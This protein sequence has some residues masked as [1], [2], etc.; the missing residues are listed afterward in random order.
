MNNLRLYAAIPCLFFFL[1]CVENEIE[2]FDVTIDIQPQGSATIEPV[3]YD[4]LF[5]GDSIS[6]TIT[7]HNDYQ[8]DQWS[9][10]VSSF[11]STIT[12]FGTQDYD[13]TALLL[14]V[15][16]LSEQVQVYI[17]PRIDPNPI[18]AIRLGAKSSVVLNKQGETVAEYEFENRLG[19]DLEMLPN[20]EFIGI[21]KPDDRDYFSFGG[22]GG[23][24]RRVTADQQTLWEYTIASETELAHHDLEILPNGNVMTIVWEEIPTEQAQALGAQTQGPIYTEKLVEIDPDTNQIVW[25]WRSVEHLIQDVDEHASTYGSI[26]ENPRKININYNSDMEDGDWMHANGIVY[27]PIR[28]LIFMTVNF[29]DEVWVI[30][31]ST[32]TAQASTSLGGNYGVGGD[33]V[34]RFGNP[35]TYNSE[36]PP[37]FDRVHHP[38][39]SNDAHSQMLFFSNGSQTEQS[40]VFELQLPNQ[41]IL[42]SDLEYLPKEVWRFTDPELYNHIVSGAV[43]LPNGNVLICEGDFGFWEVTPAGEVVWKMQGNKINFWRA[44]LFRE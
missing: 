36:T 34:Y 23:I 9:G 25:Q 10:T 11:E 7:P 2:I 17:G 39:F 3:V 26:R 13:L 29:Y 27:D 8:F 40:I 43:K 31:H 28:D 30:D 18:H 37:I 14:A 44:Y 1:S 41:L 20:G 21:F 38:N 24:L 35:A 19:N 42:D 6:I 33:L 32:T 15:P 4:T 22:S 16:D 5:P 12:L